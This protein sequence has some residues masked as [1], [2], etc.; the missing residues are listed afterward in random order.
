MKLHTIH[1]YMVI[2]ARMI[3]HKCNRY[4][5]TH[6][7]TNKH[8]RECVV[9][10]QTFVPGPSCCDPTLPCHEVFSRWECRFYWKLCCRW[11]EGLRRRRV[12]VIIQGQGIRA[13]LFIHLYY[14]MRWYRQYIDL[15]LHF[16]MGSWFHE[17]LIMSANV[18]SLSFLLNNVFWSTFYWDFTEIILVGQHGVR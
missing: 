5:F 6:T 15:C 16:C 7:W 8:M 10:H 14:H 11:L 4:Q 2:Y 18:F 3:I 1:L 17:L 13:H 9:M 12:A